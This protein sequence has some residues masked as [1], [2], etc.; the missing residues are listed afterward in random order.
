MVS[1]FGPIQAGAQL[2]KQMSVEF[3]TADQHS[4]KPRDTATFQLISHKF[5][6]KYA[7]LAM[8]KSFLK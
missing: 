2:S 7:E 8:L 6:S 3:S 5:D 4:F 1:R